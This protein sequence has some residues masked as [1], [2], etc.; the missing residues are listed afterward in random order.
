MIICC[1][2]RLNCE[3][4]GKKLKQEQVD[5]CHEGKGRASLSERQQYRFR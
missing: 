2:D 5:S 4:V 3:F 1:F